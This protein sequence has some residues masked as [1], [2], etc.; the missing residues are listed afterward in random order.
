MSSSNFSFAGI[1]RLRKSWLPGLWISLAA[2][3]TMKRLEPPAV[4]IIVLPTYDTSAW[5]RSA[6]E[7][8][9][10][11]DYPVKAF[12]SSLP[13]L[14]VLFAECLSAS[15]DYDYFRNIRYP[16]LRRPDVS[17]DRIEQAGGPD[18]TGAYNKRVV[19]WWPKRGVDVVEKPAGAIERTWTVRADA[20][21]PLASS[22]LYRTWWPESFRGKKQFKATLLG[23]RVVLAPEVKQSSN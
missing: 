14:I 15:A 16:G 3:P 20:N 6:S 8:I 10:G 21:E 22:P 5:F 9:V 17:P 19:E 4:D 12:L 2:K 11:K 18:A 23:F 13:V 1:V 7:F